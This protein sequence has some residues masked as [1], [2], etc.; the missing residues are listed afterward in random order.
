VQ[1][2]V[3][4]G[5]V[6][7]SSS[8]DQRYGLDVP[9]TGRGKPEYYFDRDKS[10]SM[11]SWKSLEAGMVNYINISVEGDLEPHLLCGRGQLEDLQ[12]T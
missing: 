2:G 3:Y 9:G 6:S 7:F 5:K 12:K 1:S 10:G 4:V 11:V 8:A